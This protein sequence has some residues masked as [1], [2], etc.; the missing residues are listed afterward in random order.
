VFV[1]ALT[2]AALG[3]AAATLSLAIASQVLDNLSSLRAIHPY[4]P[5][6]GWLAYADLFRSPVTWA[7]MERGAILYVAYVAVF[8]TAA[9]F[10]FGRRDVHS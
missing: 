10:A 3:A 1:S 4:L 2:D 6:H 8:L 7:A 9:L 5:T